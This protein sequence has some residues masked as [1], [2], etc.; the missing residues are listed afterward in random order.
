MVVIRQ[1]LYRGNK[2]IGSKVGKISM[3]ENNFLF[4]I[5]QTERF[6]KNSLFL[7]PR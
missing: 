7:Q 1:E 3:T 2:K 4:L 5:Q 6:L